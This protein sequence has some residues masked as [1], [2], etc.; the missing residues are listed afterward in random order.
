MFKLIEINSGMENKNK[1]NK[2]INKTKGNL[3]Q[4]NESES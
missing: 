3:P 1:T 2:Q 4:R